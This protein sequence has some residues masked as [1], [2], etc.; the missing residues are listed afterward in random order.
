MVGVTQ[1]VF[2]FREAYLEKLRLSPRWYAMQPIQRLVSLDAF[3]GFVMLLMAS[4]GLGL[5]QMA[6]LYPDSWGWQQIKY[7][8]SHVPW[9]GCSL[10]DLIQ[11]SFMFM[12]GIAVPLSVT[13]RKEAGQGFIGLTC[14]SLIRA[15][16]LVLLAV[17]LSTGGKEKQTLWIFT[18]VLAQI[19]LGYVFLSILARLGW[20]YCV[21][22][23]VVIL[24]GD[25]FWFFQH[26]LPAEGCDYASLGVLKEDLLPG[27]FGH[28]SKGLNVAADFDR[29]LLNLLPHAQP[30]IA[31]AGGYTTLNFIPSLATMLGG[32]ITGNFL[33]TSPRSQLQKCGMWCDCKCISLYLICVCN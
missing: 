22:A 11:P 7:Q 3:R 21:S 13:R 27:F 2:C 25:W 32:A 23:I 20:E 18:N 16:S 29:W 6:S 14:H 1:T 28:W 17:L 15:L 26:P 33:I 5:A 9:V 8:V 31:N 12:V 10:W 24:V 19:G 4:S 30:F